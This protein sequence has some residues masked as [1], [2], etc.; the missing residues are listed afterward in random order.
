MN[1]DKKLSRALN[2]L[3]ELFKITE[4]VKIKKEKILIFLLCLFYV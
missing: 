1:A 2:D 3:G 4:F